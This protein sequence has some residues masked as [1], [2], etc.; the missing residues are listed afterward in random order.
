[1][2]TNIKVEMNNTQK[3]L[4]KRY[5]NKDGGAQV[6]FTKECAKAMN[7]YTPYLHGRLKDM[8]IE[9]QADK[10]IYNAPYAARQYYTNKGMGKQGENQGGLRGKMWDKRMWIDKGDGIVKTIAE[11]VGGKSK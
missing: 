6:K 5:L 1:M 8:M 9:L 4:L 7:N 3:I 2:A 10:V 11:F